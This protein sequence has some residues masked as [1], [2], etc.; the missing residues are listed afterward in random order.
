MNEILEYGAIV[1]R[2]SQGENRG[3]CNK[4]CPRT[5][6]LTLRVLIL[7]PFPC[8]VFGFRKSPR[9]YSNQLDCQQIFPQ[10]RR[11]N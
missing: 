7:N 11:R 2:Y 4:S 10:K 3:V 5:T 8:C 6:N 9:R 1:E